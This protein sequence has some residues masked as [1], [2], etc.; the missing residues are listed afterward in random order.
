MQGDLDP[1][2]AVIGNRVRIRR[3]S[4]NISQ[5][6]LGDAL[7]MTYQQVQK[8]EKGTNRILASRLV[9]IARLLKTPLAFFYDNLDG[10]DTPATV[11]HYTG[12]AI[13]M[14]NAFQKIPSP[15][16]RV[17]LLNIAMVASSMGNGK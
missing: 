16:V 17:A 2:D 8:Y 10:A 4:L 9:H 7:G 1:I 12:E 14:A 13:T 15:E 3:M 6:A 11:T 5:T